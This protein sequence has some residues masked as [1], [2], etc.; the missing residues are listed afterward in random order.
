[1]KK[2]TIITIVSMVLFSG[3]SSMQKYS[4]SD[5]SSEGITY[6]KGTRMGVQSGDKVRALLRTC[7]R[8]DNPGSKTCGY[9]TIGMLTVVR[10]NEDS[11]ILKKDESFSMQGEVFLKK[12]TNK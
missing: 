1:M 7:S 3:C 10:A 4:S 12:E 9:K 11:S 5:D 8:E 6:N 2:I